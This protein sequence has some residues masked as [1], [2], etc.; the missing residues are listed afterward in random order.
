[1]RKM[2]ELQ[3]GNLIDLSRLLVETRIPIR[4]LAELL[5]V[6]IP[7]RLGRVLDSKPKGK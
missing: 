3:Y 2:A 5:G 1:M 6:E 4:T 7:K